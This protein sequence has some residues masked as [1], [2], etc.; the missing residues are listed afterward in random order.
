MGRYV[1]S[2]AEAQIALKCFPKPKNEPQVAPC[3]MFELGN[4]LRLQGT[5]KLYN[6]CTLI[7]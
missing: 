6:E 2:A 7:I 1:E 3:A 4:A 5:L